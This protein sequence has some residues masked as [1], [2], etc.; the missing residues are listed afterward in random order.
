[1]LHSEFAKIL[2]K[3]GK[4]EFRKDLESLMISLEKYTNLLTLNIGKISIP[5]FQAQ[6]FNPKAKSFNDFKEPYRLVIGHV[7]A[8]AHKNITED[9]HIRSQLKLKLFICHVINRVFNN[10]HNEGIFIHFENY[11]NKKP[12]FGK[13]IE[14]AK[15]FSFREFR[16]WINGEEP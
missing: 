4:G 7:F 13:K 6:M 5:E 10:E 15:G 16:E 2:E 11:C 1:M 8:K 9:I 12:Q 3:T 14:S